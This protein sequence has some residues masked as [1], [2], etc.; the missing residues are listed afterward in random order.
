VRAG[1]RRDDRNGAEFLDT[2]FDE[3]AEVAPE[4]EPLDEGA[5]RA[6]RDVGEA[7]AEYDRWLDANHAAAEAWFAKNGSDTDVEPTFDSRRAAHAAPEYG[8]LAAELSPRW[9][10]GWTPD[11]RR[12]LRTRAAQECVDL[13]EMKRRALEV[14]LRL[15]YEQGM[16]PWRPRSD[17]HSPP[18]IP[19]QDL[20]RAEFDRWLRV[21][22]RK[23]AS[24][25]LL[26]RPYPEAPSE[27]AESELTETGGAAD[28]EN[29]AGDSAPGTRLEELGQAFNDLGGDDADD[30]P[31]QL[32]DEDYTALL[33]EL[34]SLASPAEWRT[35]ETL[36]QLAKPSWAAVDRALAR[37][38]GQTRVLFKRLKDKYRRTQ[39]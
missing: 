25:W 7:I 3:L 22:A 11:V 14:G 36:L 32:A 38:P 26:D 24:C 19:A 37:A 1:V 39:G 9:K 13:D 27:I 20:G 35:I 23:A 29:A 12:A 4:G 5:A 6:W 8:T 16:H 10:V 34:K 15:A 31:D 2:I 18:I 17:S 21:E 33:D 28:Y 30:V